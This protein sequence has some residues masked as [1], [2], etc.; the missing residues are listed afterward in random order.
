MPSKRN[1][2]PFKIPKNN[3]MIAIAETT[4]ADISGKLIPKGI[5]KNAAIIMVLTYPSINVAVA[6]KTAYLIEVLSDMQYME[7]TARTIKN[8]LMSSFIFF[9][10][11]EMPLEQLNYIIMVY[12]VNVDNIHHIVY[13]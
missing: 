4:P 3:P 8:V 2:P 13:T 7:D 11:L 1:G 12:I 5:D 10:T 6:S 9:T